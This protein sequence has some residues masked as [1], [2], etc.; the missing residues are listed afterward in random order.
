MPSDLTGFAGAGKRKSSLSNW[1]MVYRASYFGCFSVPVFC[2]SW[3]AFSNVMPTSAT[4]LSN[5]SA[6]HG[7][8]TLTSWLGRWLNVFAVRYRLHTLL[9]LLTKGF[10]YLTPSCRQLENRDFV[11]EINV[12]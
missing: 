9:L 7:S 1:V 5:C 3:L 2:C 10:E 8:V 6:A 12:L 11:A 4:A